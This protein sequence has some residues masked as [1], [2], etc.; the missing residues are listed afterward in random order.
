VTR[1]RAADERS[2]RRVADLLANPFA[3]GTVDDWRRQVNDALKAAIGAEQAA[4]MLPIADQQ[5]VFSDE[6]D[7]SIAAQYPN[8]HPP[9]LRDGRSIWQAALEQRVVTCR[10]IYGNDYRDYESSPYFN[11]YAAPNRCH[12]VV[13]ALGSL[14][15]AT[16]HLLAGVQ[17]WRDD[18]ARRRFGRRELTM[19]RRLEPALRTGIAMQVRFAEHRCSVIG[20]LDALGERAMLVDPRGRPLH[21]TPAMAR[22]LADGPAALVLREALRV[23]LSAP[24]NGRERVCKVSAGEWRLRSCE[25]PAPTASAPTLALIVAERRKAERLG[26]DALRIQYG[27]TPAEA[28]V[29]VLLADGASNAAVAAALSIRPATA[30]RHTEKVLAKLGVRRR[31]AVASKVLRWD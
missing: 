6:L 27:L 3:A 25:I 10:T 7:P 17:L 9:D 31:A 28:R 23:L 8:L 18:R 5:L 21:S 11:E 4:F 16:P 14:G 30:R 12:D 13:A 29:A 2:L 19:L 1:L 20:V 26:A 22:L 24:T 15:G